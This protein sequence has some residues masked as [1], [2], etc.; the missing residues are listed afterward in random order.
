[1]HGLGNNQAS[2]R[3]EKQSGFPTP[4][5]PCS[6]FSAN[7]AMP[8]HGPPSFFLALKSKASPLKLYSFLFVHFFLKKKIVTTNIF[9]KQSILVHSN[10]W[11]QKFFK[12]FSW[13][14]MKY[15]NFHFETN[16]NTMRFNMHSIC[17]L[18]HI[19]LH[20]WK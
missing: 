6:A 7:T 8:M 1:M 5:H 2:M 3:M 16:W 14:I 15:P 20:R 11:L 4:P 18:A 10:G 17:T 12:L 13:S 9:Q 19:G